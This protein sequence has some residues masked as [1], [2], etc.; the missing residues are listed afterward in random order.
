M[1]KYSIRYF[2]AIFALTL[3]AFV[4]S[5]QITNNLN[6]RTLPSGPFKFSGFVGHP[7]IG[8]PGAEPEGKMV[9]SVSLEERKKDCAFFGGDSLQGFNF[10][11]ASAKLIADNYTLYPEFQTMMFREEIAFIKK[12][13]HITSLPG[14]DAQSGS[15]F[16]MPS[17]LVSAC[18]NL[19]F[20][21][22]DFSNWVGASGDNQNSNAPLTLL[23]ALTAATNQ[24]IYGCAD[25]NL[26]TGAYG[27]D[28]AGGFPGVDPLPGGGLYSCRLGGFNINTSS[29]YGFGCAAQHWTFGSYSNGEV[30][31]QSFVVSAANALVAFDYA[32]VL[33]DGGHPNGSQPYFHVYVTNSAGVILNTTCTQ[34]YV[35][36]PAGSPPPGFFNTGYV[37]TFDNSVIYAQ[38]WK[39]GSINLTPYIGTS[40]NVRFIAAGCTAGAHPGWA[41]VDATCGPANIIVGNANPCTGSTTIL[42][43]PP[44]SGGSYAWSGPGVVGP[45]NTQ[46]I[47][48]N[49]SGTYTVVVTPP[50]GAACQYS[51]TQTVNFITSPTLAASASPASLCSGNSTTISAN[52]TNAT[53]YSWNPGGSTAGSI[54]VT[55]PV[56]SN[57]Y[58]V[59]VT[60]GGFC[61]VSQVVTVSVTA[62]PTVNI[63]GTTAICSGNSTVLTGSGATTYS[64][65]P[66][67]STSSG[68]SVNPSTTTTYTLIGF[69]GACTSNNVVT[70]NVTPTPTLTISGSTTL[71]S[72]QS[73]VLTGATA[74]NYNWSTGAT[75]N[76]IS[77]T[78][79]TGTTNYTLTGTNGACV[80]TKTVA[81][82]VTATPTV[83]ISGTLNLCSGASTT[84]TGATAAGYTWSTGSN[85]NTIS[86]TPPVGSTTYT[87]T[88]ANGVCTAS[89]TAT[90]NVT[91]TPTVN[92]SGTLALCSGQSTVLTGATA[93]NYTWSTGSNSNTISVTPPVGST[94]YTLTGANG[95]CTATTSATVNVTATP[96]L[97]ISGTLNLCSGASTT[98]TGATAT[99]YTWSTGSNSNT[100]SVTPPVGSTTYTLTGANG[101]CTA[102]TTATVNVTTTP[103]VNI[104]G[105]LALCSGQSTVLTGATATNY[106]WSTG[107]NSNTISVT[108]PA[109][110]T[111]YTL[112]GANGVCTATA[113]ATVNVTAT[114]TVTIS[115]TL[116]LCSGASTTLTGATAAGYTWSTGSNSN[117]ISVTP[118]VGST[119]YTLT[120]ANGVCTATTTATVNV[121]TT[122]TI[123]ITGAAPICSGQSIVLTGGTAINYT[124]SPSGGNGSSATVTPGTTT[125]YTLTGANGVCVS[126]A[127]VSVNVTPTPTITITGAGPICSGSS[128]VLT[129]GTATN[130]TWSPTGGNGS[131]TT[132]TP[133][134]TTTYTLTGANGNC[135]NTAV[136]TINVTTTPTVSISGAAP[137]CSGASVVLTGGTATNYTWSPAGGNGSSATVTPGTTTTYTL[138]GANG[139]CTASATASVSVTPT[140]TVNI[141]GATAICNGASITLNGATA[142]SYSWSPGGSTTGSISVNPSTNTTYTLVGTNGTCTASAVATV[143]V[144]PLPI[145]GTA[146][147]TAAPCG[148]S[149]GC[150]NSVSVSGGTPGYTYSW[151]GG[152]F[153]GTVQNCNQ[154]AGAYVLIVNDANGCQAT[155]NFAIPSQN[156]PSA[157]TVV[158][159]TT[160]AC[161][162]DNVVLTINPITGGTTYTWTDITGTHTGTTYTITNIGPSGSYNVSVSATDGSGCVSAA[163]NLTI[164]VNPPPVINASASPVVI[165]A[166][167]STTLNANGATSYTWSANAGSVTTNTASVTPGTSDTYTV[168]GST[169]GCVSSQTVAVTVNPLPVVTA[170]AA[171]ATICA[172]Q[173]TVLTANGATTYTWS[174]TATTSTISVSPSTTATYTV[175]GEV[176]GCT[177]TQTVLINVTPL[178]NILITPSPPSICAGQSSV[179]T[180]GGATTYTWS[181]NA[182]GGSATSVTVTPGGTTTYTLSGTQNGCVDSSVVTISIGNPPTIT[183]AASS[184]VMCSGGTTTLTASGATNYTWTPGSLT[185]GTVVVSPTANTIY[186]V[187][188][189]SGGC[190]STLTIAVNVTPTPTISVAASAGAICSGATT[191]LTANGSLS[192]TW[193]P[194]GATTSTVV[195]TPNTTTTY[196]VVSDSAGCSSQQQVT[197][198]V[199]A[200]PT[201]TANSSQATICSSQTATLTA[202]GATNY[203]WTPGGTGGT[204][205]VTPN[206]NTTYT[207][208]GANGNCVSTETVSVGVTPSPTITVS[209]S[210]AAVCSGQT[211]TLTASGATTYTWMPTGTN[212]DTLTDAP[213]STTIYTVTGD[214]SGCTNTQQVSVTVN[215]IPTVAPVASQT[216]CSGAQVAPINYSAGTSTVNWTNTNINIG[217]GASGSG[218]IAGYTAPNVVTQQ[219]GIITATPTDNGTGCSGTA[220]TYTVIINPA[221]TAVGGQVDSAKCGVANGGVT[222][223]TVSG[224]TPAYTYQWYNNGVIM[225]G[226]TNPTLSNV[227][228]GNY[229]VLISDANGCSAAATATSFTVNGSIAVVASFTASVY[230][231]QA[232]LNVVFTNGT[233]GASSYNWNLGNGTTTGPTAATTYNASGTYTVILTA[234]NGTCFDTASAVIIVDASTSIVIPNIY[235]PNGDGLNDIFFITTTG[236]RTLHCDIFNRWGQLVYTLKGPNDSWDGILNNGNAASE[237]TYYYILNAE[238]YDGKTYKAE[239]HLTLV[240]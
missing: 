82:T 71:C 157:P 66:S 54:T 215:P 163:T 230:T 49:A 13:Y 35:Q 50:Q 134:T 113:S 98:L 147:I 195:V 220:E 184:T 69:N 150:I 73:T 179:L 62:T 146:S 207:V 158:P 200:T 39:S 138:T 65:Q 112:T 231:G 111:T 5:A 90:V 31:Q 32:V 115:G 61:P 29:G 188:A 201:L 16:S 55:P 127:V 167:Q 140:P 239:G 121:T 123:T 212:N 99:G 226:E 131:S 97:S 57:S 142:T 205:T 68:I 135:T 2:S 154:P 137:I 233:I 83:N 186:T 103:T 79:P 114:P 95:A 145:I 100:I 17:V 194:G 125:S 84:L 178:P 198:N 173:S 192:Y 51:L 45:N 216:V 63:S 149:T 26:I 33:N 196:T 203:T 109:G 92:I 227:A 34:Y 9:S 177:A 124:W 166:G 53:S 74:T 160:V 30:L 42:T 156:G 60:N 168:T 18:A 19:D 197:I 12:K 130:Y 76:T 24:N 143:T 217:I 15:R 161:V 22:G 116:N 237:G 106:T 102:S 94:T 20:E 164:T 38:N 162:G 169:L 151:N 199:T 136:A 126:S 44:V 185:T 181:T 6:D 58:T 80:S 234:S 56:G 91:T 96:T 182:G 27:N 75:T 105:T 144:N 193:S 139:A 81:V 152:P 209:A 129:G 172:G 153:T 238:G 108:P 159:S 202:S 170:N 47:T 191:T 210:S 117:T 41:Y 183:A 77:V 46:V 211:A 3:F 218:N 10:D 221:P 171:P 236:M 8:K 141:T 119:T 222:G 64:W 228:I 86:V 213:T 59:T 204:I 148:Q 189:T 235:S 28:L 48:V 208:T 110:S 180:A 225:A 176:A 120:G 132:V 128:V 206:A 67:G 175:T 21:N 52:A 7:S 229:S 174:T 104:S 155:Q 224:G 14:E 219:I 72:G 43:A 165:C 23:G 88:G 93:T 190:A 37:N 85:S 214:N 223:I 1:N 122:P 25:V 4:S 240:K 107:S 40:V 70:V 78:P 232:P 101:V 187:S 118:P 89:T 11:I 133:A 87:L 36:A